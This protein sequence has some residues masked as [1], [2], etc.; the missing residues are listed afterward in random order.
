MNA[1]TF[2]LFSNHSETV[3]IFDEQ[4]V[5]AGVQSV[6]YLRSHDQMTTSMLD[7]SQSWTNGHS[8]TISPNSQVIVY[9]KI[10]DRSGNYHYVSTQGFV[11]DDQISKPQIDIVTPQPLNHI[12]NGDVNVRVQVTDPDPTGNHDYAG[13]KSV[14]W[15]VRN[16]G[17]MTQSGNLSVTAGATRQQSAEGIIRV[18][19]RANNSNHVQIYVR[20][21]DNADN[22]SEETLDL[23]IDIT[24]PTISVSFDNNSPQNGKYYRTTRT[25]TVTVTERNFDPDNVQIRVT[26]TDGVQ[27]QITG[28]SHSANSGESD[29]ATHTANI[30]FSADGD[31]NFTVDCTDLALNRASNPYTS[32]EFTIDKTVPRISVSYNNNSS[33]NGS[34]YKAERTATVTIMEHNFNASGVEL[35]TTASAGGAPRLS[36]W[37]GSGDRH[38]A[39]ITFGNDADYTFGLSYTDLA[40]NQADPYGQDSFT[41]DLTNPEL[42]ITGVANHPA[43]KGVVAPVITTSDTNFT[44]GGVSITLRGAN[45]GTI[46]IDSMISRSAQ[47]GGQVISF[48]N[49]GEHMDDIYTLTAKVVDMAGNETTE[50]ITFS[51]N[52]EGSTYQLSSDTQ[53][54]L[55]D[56]FTN[57]P[58]DLVIKEINVDTLEF[59]EITYS[60]DGQVVTLKEGE[61]YT[62]AEAGGNGQWKTYTYTIFAD[63]FEEEGEYSINIYSEDRAEIPAP[64]G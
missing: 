28:W 51:V 41:V 34:Y 16:N 61:D 4:D 50:T 64:T 2:G 54:L 5:T 42:S 11:L 3:T 46:D 8:L 7:Q 55:D 24:A 12:Y 39:V 60:K 49:F 23:S 22:V 33:Q 17:R 57:N 30:I 6:Q 40:G 13:L 58:P 10:T 31:Y 48:A 21:V 43:N 45:K 35:R 63:C 19:S 53:K 44:A 29:S 56:K 25:A 52:R 26:N 37:S 9:G 15:E 38:T 32:E 18:D 27:P 47:A 62:V 1:I 20:A 14:Y 36:G 59:I